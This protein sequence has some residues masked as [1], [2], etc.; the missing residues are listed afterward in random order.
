[1]K[2]VMENQAEQAEQAAGQANTEEL[3]DTKRKLEGSKR[4]TEYTV[5]NKDSRQNPNEQ[6]NSIPTYGH[7]AS[8]F[9]LT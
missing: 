8:F 9:P 7:C 6:L 4:P 1:M 2:S 5:K 3:C